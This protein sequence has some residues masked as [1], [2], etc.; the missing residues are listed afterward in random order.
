MPASGRKR[1]SARAGERRTEHGTIRSMP[2]EDSLRR[3]A[4]L[5]EEIRIRLWF[6]EQV[7]GDLLRPVRGDLEP[8]DALRFESLILQLR[9]VLELLA[10]ATLSA[11]ERQAVAVDPELARMWKAKKILDLVGKVNPAFFPAA[12][13]RE[14]VEAGHMRLLPS[15]GR[16]LFGKQDFVQLY[17]ACGEFLHAMNP[18]APR[19]PVVVPWPVGETIAR[20]RNLLRLHVVNLSDTQKMLV[21]VPDSIAEPVHVYRLGVADVE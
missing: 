20:I 1:S 16:P 2:N 9:K 6:T 14:V 18:F 12:M 5:M 4:N 21:E 19:L 7:G 8:G 15:F 11:H 13:L 3:Y 17:D 10:F